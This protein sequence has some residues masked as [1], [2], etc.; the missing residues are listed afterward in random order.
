VQLEDF[1]KPK[2]V[3]REIGVEMDACLLSEEFVVNNKL[4]LL[5]G[6]YLDYLLAFFNSRLF[7]KILMKTA[8]ITGGKGADFMYNV[9]VPK[10]TKTI[11][12]ALSVDDFASNIEAQKHVDELFFELVG[13]SMQE[14]SYVND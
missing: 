3:Y 8:N 7:N 14:Q 13:L 9:R 10:P 1:N 5:T 6:D 11:L 12:Q 4:Y 2:I